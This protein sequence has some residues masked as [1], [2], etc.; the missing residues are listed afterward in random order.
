MR[1]ADGSEQPLLTSAQLPTGTKWL[2]TPAVSPDGARLCVVAVTDENLTALWILSLSAGR[3]VRLT[4]VAEPKE[5]GGSWSPDGSRFVYLVGR[6]GFVDL[7][8]VKTTGEAPPTLL[9]S[10]VA[11]SLPEWSADGKWIKF[12][13]PKDGWSLLSPD[14]K[15]VRSFGTLDGAIEVTVS[16]DGSQFHGLRF[17]DEKLFLFRF[18]LSTRKQTDSGEI[19]RDNYPQSSLVPGIRLSLSADGKSI[20]YQSIQYRSSL[21]MLEGFPQPSFWG[22]VQDLFL[23]R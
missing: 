7:W 4:N 18:D 5:F 8:V 23:R 12:R 11:S 22:R 2:M 13:D 15:E 1:A 14:G 17:K 10:K 20:L 6:S 19:D 3:P 21:W 9:R 16:Q